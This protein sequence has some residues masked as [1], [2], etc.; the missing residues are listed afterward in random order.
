MYLYVALAAI[1]AVVMA[2]ILIWQYGLIDR[3]IKD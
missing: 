1:P 3:Q 2:G